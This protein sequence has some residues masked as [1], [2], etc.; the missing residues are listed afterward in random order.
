MTVDD[1]TIKT[2]RQL[3]CELKLDEEVDMILYLDTNMENTKK[4]KL[5]KTDYHHVQAP[6]DLEPED[7]LASDQKTSSFDLEMLYEKFVVFKDKLAKRFRKPKEAEGG[8]QKADNNCSPGDEMT[9]ELTDAWNLFTRVI[10]S[11]GLGLGR[12]LRGR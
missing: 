8:E 5:V 10:I 6:Y 12:G 11:K 1:E 2:L 7:W 9:Q 4:T 3:H